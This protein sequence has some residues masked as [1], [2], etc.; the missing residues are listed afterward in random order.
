MNVDLIKY[1]NERQKITIL[2]LNN[3]LECVQI[4]KIKGLY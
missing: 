2:N 1:E 4:I 3:L